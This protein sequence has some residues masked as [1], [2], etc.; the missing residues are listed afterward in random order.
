[1]LEATNNPARKANYEM[2]LSFV[3]DTSQERPPMKS[4]ESIETQ[5]M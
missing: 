1:M 2:R 3:K 4:C 5:I